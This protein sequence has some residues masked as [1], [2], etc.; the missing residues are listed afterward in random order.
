[1]TAAKERNQLVLSFL[2]VRRLLGL[3]GVALPVILVVFGLAVNNRIEDSVSAFYYTG[4][5]DVFVGILCAIGV[6]LFAY[7]GYPPEIGE[8]ITDRRVS[9][10]AGVGAVVTALFPP[11]DPNAPDCE[12]VTCTITGLPGSALHFAGAGTFFAAMAV[13]CL[14]L[15]TRSAPGTQPDAD[16]RRANAIYRWCGIAI[17]LM[18]SGLVAIFLLVTP[19]SSLD[20]QLKAVNL[21]FWLEAVAIIAFSTAWLVKGETLLRLFGINP[22]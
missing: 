13:F 3:L 16:K 2:T 4:M 7:K 6:F 9:R 20:L 5:G 14:V 17:L 11:F 18:L 1:M 19:G 10:V 8:H 22:D 21:V 12:V 15:F